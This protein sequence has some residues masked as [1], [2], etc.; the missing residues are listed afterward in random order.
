MANAALKSFGGRVEVRGVVEEVEWR[1]AV[2]ED[3]VVEVGI[4]CVGVWGV[5]MMIEL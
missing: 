2:E 4:G 5:M 3:I 1:D